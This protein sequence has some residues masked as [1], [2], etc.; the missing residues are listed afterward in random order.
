MLSIKS[1]NANNKVSSRATSV[2]KLV[3][4]LHQVLIFINFLYLTFIVI[5][6]LIGDEIVRIVILNNLNTYSLNM[7]L[8]FKIINLNYKINKKYI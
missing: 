8:I 6:C 5:I 4:K 3:N 1:R 7:K 2:I